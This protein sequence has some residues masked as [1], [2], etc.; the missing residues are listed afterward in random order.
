M[1][2]KPEPSKR[3]CVLDDD[4]ETVAM[5]WFNEVDSYCSEID[6]ERSDDVVRDHDSNSIV[7][8]NRH[9]PNA[10]CVEDDSLG[11]LN[12]LKDFLC[13]NI[14]FEDI[15]LTPIP[16]HPDFKFSMITENHQTIN[17]HP[18]F[19]RHDLLRN[20]D[21]DIFEMLKQVHSP[22]ALTR[23]NSNFVNIF[24]KCND[25]LH[26]FLPKIC[27]GGSIRA[28]L[29]K[30]LVER[31]DHAALWEYRILISTPIRVNIP[32]TAT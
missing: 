11:A 16:A 12:G 25:V 30:K 24:R 15:P 26:Y 13:N 2:P 10:N 22:K 14:G 3:V 1:E 32:C 20:S 31:C 28:S 21:D 17:A 29:I 4:F 19:A 8:G 5:Q 9:S 27:C 23:P 7:D 6:S 18:Y